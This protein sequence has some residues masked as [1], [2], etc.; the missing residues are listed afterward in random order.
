MSNKSDDLLVQNKKKIEECRLA[1]LNSVAYKRGVPS[2]LGCS[3]PLE[4]CGKTI[5]RPRDLL[6][7]IRAAH[8]L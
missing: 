7:H 4:N 8:K 6:L 5:S 3:C 2:A 1:K